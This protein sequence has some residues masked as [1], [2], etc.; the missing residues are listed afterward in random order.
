V[1]GEK[2]YSKY[3]IALHRKWLVQVNLPS[4]HVGEP[5]IFPVLLKATIFKLSPSTN[6]NSSSLVLSSPF[7]KIMMSLYGLS[8]STTEINVGR[9]TF[10]NI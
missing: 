10:V 8:L 5:T 6:C 3:R 9:S 1:T 4:V 7:T 2:E